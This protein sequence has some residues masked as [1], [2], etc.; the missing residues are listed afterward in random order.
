VVGIGVF[1]AGCGVLLAVLGGHRR[2]LRT[3]GIGFGT[4]PEVALLLIG[5][6]VLI[7]LR[8]SLQTAPHDTSPDPAD[9]ESKNEGG[10]RPEAPTS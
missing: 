5:L 3:F 1:L 10:A 2:L 6:G 4:A 8:E 7:L 9:D